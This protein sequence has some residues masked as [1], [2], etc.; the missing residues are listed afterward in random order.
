M[1]YRIL[2][3]GAGHGGLSAAAILA[4]NGYDVTVVEKSNLRDMGYDWHDVFDLDT[5]DFA[6]IPR[7]D[8]SLLG[9]YDG[10]A[11][12]GPTFDSIV[13]FDNGH[14][15]NTISMDRKVLIRHLI[16]HCKSCGVKFVFGAEITGPVMSG[17]RVIGFST[18]GKKGKKTYYGD[19]VIDAAGMDSPI[20]LGLPDKCGIVRDF[21]DTDKIFIYRAYYNKVEVPDFESPYKYLVSCYHLCRPGIDWIDVDEDYVDILIGKFGELH[22]EEVEA[23]LEDLREHDPRLGTEVI[24]GGQYV[25]IPIGAAIP[26]LVC[27]GLAIVGDSASMVVP[28]TGSGITASIKAGKL[29]ASTVMND[30]EGDFTTETLWSYQYRYFKSV[31]KDFMPIYMLR[32]V[33]TAL[34]PE[35]VDFLFKNIVK[36]KLINAATGGNVSGIPVSTVLEMAIKGLPKAKLMAD[37]AAAAISTGEG[38][39]IAE[40]IP[41]EYD[42][43]AVEAWKKEY[44]ALLAI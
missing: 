13:E 28:I 20:R 37:L 32:K 34:E 30:R 38:V 43:R 18:K 15:P 44:S 4:K 22:P 2:V 41:M 29:L 33:L 21:A 7:P 14:S 17:S 36:S 19:L 40:K 25:S 12:C 35:D 11:F 10:D 42:K 5:F 16:D 8:E 3:A 31:Q 26:M 24:R 9:T 27:D 6:D 1:S 39:A 23:A